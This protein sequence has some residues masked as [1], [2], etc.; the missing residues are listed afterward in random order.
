MKIHTT[1]NFEVKSWDE[2]PYSEIAGQ[3]KLTRADPLKTLTN[4]DI[5]FILEA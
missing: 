2:K 4:C 3:P 5:L 1:G